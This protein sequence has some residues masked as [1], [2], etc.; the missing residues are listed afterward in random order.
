MFRRFAAEVFRIQVISNPIA[1]SPITPYTSGSGTAISFFHLKKGS[2]YI[3]ATT[4][5]NANA[6][7]IFELLS[8]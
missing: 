1:Q 2:V 5:M 7:L 8:K 3:V 6:A 4:K